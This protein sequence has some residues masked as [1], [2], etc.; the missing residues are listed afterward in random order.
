MFDVPCWTG[1][2]LSVRVHGIR[3][4]PVVVGSLC[5]KRKPNPLANS[6]SSSYVLLLSHESYQIPHPWRDATVVPRVVSSN[7]NSK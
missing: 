3:G 1:G 2:D 7:F 6:V 5:D 4:E